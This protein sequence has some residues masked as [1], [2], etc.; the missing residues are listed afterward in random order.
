MT[1]S[2]LNPLKGSENNDKDS[3]LNFY[4]RQI[5][6]FYPISLTE[7]FISIAYIGNKTNV[8]PVKNFKR[9]LREKEAF[10]I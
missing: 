1:F 10:A 8:F 9:R 2:T 3:I 6:N 4:K 5:I 7:Y